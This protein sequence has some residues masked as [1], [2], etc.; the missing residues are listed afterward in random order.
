MTRLYGAQEERAIDHQRRGL[1]RDVAI[2]RGAAHFARAVGPGNPQLRDVGAI[3]L[4]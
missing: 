3:D 4:R 2:R 1:E